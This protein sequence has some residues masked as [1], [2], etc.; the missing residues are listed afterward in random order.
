MNN[1]NNI[2]IYKVKHL[3]PTNS[4][5][6]GLLYNGENVIFKKND[7]FEVDGIKYK[8][9]DFFNYEPYESKLDKGIQILK[10]IKET[11]PCI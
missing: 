1:I 2:N 6:V 11:I 5:I 4:G 9:I 3:H 8:M 10:T 7:I